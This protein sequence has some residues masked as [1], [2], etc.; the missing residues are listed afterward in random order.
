M[1]YEEL[2]VIIVTVVLVKTMHYCMVSELEKNKTK[3]KTKQ[4]K[5]QKKK[6]KQSFNNMAIP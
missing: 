1:L 5:K 3:Q 2:S 4:K 6:K